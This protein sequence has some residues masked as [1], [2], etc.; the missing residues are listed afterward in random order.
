M[1]RKAVFVALLLLSLS[2]TAAIS[3]PQCDQASTLA[4]SHVRRTRASHNSIDRSAFDQKCRVVFTQFVE[5][6]A[7]RQA[8]AT[9]Q[10]GVS[11]QSA[12]KVIDAEIQ[13]I[14]DHIAEQSCVQ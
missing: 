13:I 1:R 10:D 9:C 12:L 5:A 6:V 8:A 11:R 7:A 4:A 3:D 2:T 14:N